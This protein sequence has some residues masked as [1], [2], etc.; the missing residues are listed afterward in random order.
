VKTK[1]TKETIGRQKERKELWNTNRI[2]KKTMGG[3]NKGAKE[4]M[5]TRV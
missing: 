3:S 2:T 1:G 5:E 4:T